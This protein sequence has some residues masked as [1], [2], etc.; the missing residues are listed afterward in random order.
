MDRTG[1]P[2]AGARTVFAEEVADEE[3]VD[4]AAPRADGDVHV[5]GLLP[6]A[7]EVVIPLGVLRLP[8]RL[9]RQPPPL[10]LLLPLITAGGG[11]GRRRRRGRRAEHRRGAGAE[12]AP[13][14]G[15][16]DGAS[17]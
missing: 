7:V 9:L 12:A 17:G 16:Q 13:V 5:V 14:G 10:L 2:S 15:S 11:L 3:V 1:H 6:E 8:R 4:D